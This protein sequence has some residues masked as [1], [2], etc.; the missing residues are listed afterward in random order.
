[1]NRDDFGRLLG[2]VYR[3]D[4]GIFVNYEIVR[5]G[6][7]QPLTIEPNTTYRELFVDAAS[8]AEARRCR[9]VE[10]LRRLT[11]RVPLGGRR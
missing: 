1:M 5:Q 8:A 2:Y 6:F 10:R 7:A 4:D 11:H 9:P 3:A